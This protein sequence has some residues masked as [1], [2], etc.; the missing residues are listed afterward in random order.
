M[1][2]ITPTLMLNEN[3]LVFTFIRSSGPGGQHVNKVATGVQLK[4]NVLGSSSLPEDVRWRLLKLAKN[5]INSDGVLTITAHQF[6]MQG[7]NRQDAQD[8]LVELIRQAA[9]KPKFRVPTRRTRSSRERRLV[10]KK[11]RQ[12][13]KK[14]RRITGEFE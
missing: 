4:F 7:Q 1:L 9:F 5:R 10:A 13:I 14:A 11:H 3:E 12:T 8:R 6:R 2:T